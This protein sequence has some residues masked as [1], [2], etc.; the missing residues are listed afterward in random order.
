MRF[1]MLPKSKQR[2]A[3]WKMIDRVRLKSD[4]KAQIKGNIIMLAVCYL[5]LVAI[6]LVL[7]FIPIL[8]AFVSF[9]V[10]AATSVALLRLYLGLAQG[11]PPEVSTVVNTVKEPIVL[12]NSVLTGLLMGIFVMLWSLLLV[13][14]GIIKSISYS[15]SFYILAED[16]S[17]GAMNAI[18]ESKRIMEGHKMEYFILQL[19]FI[20]WVLLVGA[21]FGLAGFYVFP[22]IQQT[23]TNFYLEIK[24]QQQP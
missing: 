18:N 6:M 4:A 10:S 15:M 2:K 17:I 11:I 22:Y 8:G 1:G 21:T 20:P 16:P 7:N 24:K 19:S 5:V 9:L 14:P 3:W 12:I 13:I 23:I